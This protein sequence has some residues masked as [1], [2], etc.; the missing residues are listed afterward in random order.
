[1]ADGKPGRVKLQVD[2]DI[3]DAH[4]EAHCTGT[5]IAGVLG[6]CAETLYIR[7]REDKGMTF[8]EYMYSKRD[9]GKAHVKHKQYEEALKGDRGM[10]VWLGKNWLDQKDNHDVNVTGS[11]SVSVINYGDDPEPKPYENDKVEGEE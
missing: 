4:L 6:M 5:Q 1:M 8:E 11:M 2:W 7:C 3:V 10:L 9:K